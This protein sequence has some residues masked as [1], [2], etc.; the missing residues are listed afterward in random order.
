[1]FFI[2]LTGIILIATF[3]LLGFYI[4]SKACHSALYRSIAGNLSFSS[5]TIATNLKNMEK[6]SEVLLASP[7]IQDSLKNIDRDQKSAADSFYSDQINHQLIANYYAYRESGVAFVTIFN[8]RFANSTNI[9]AQKKKEPA[10]LN[11]ALK[12][13]KEAQ[14]AVAWTYGDSN[15]QDIYLTRLIREI[16]G[17]KFTS[18]G[19]ILISVDMDTLIQS[20]NLPFQSFENSSY[21]LYD[22]DN[23][24]YS[25]ANLSAELFQ[26]ALSV[27]ANE[28]K[29]IHMKNKSYFA[30]CT[31]IP[32]YG[33]HY[34]NL[35]PYNA[36]RSSLEFATLWMV[37]VLFL[38][39]ALAIGLS[40][41]LIRSI[42]V[43]FNTLLSKMDGLGEENLTLKETGYDYSERTDEIGQL[44]Q[45]FD[46]MAKQITH[47]INVNYKNQLLTKEAQIKALESQINPHFLYNALESINW[48]ARSEHHVEISQI[49]ESLGVLLREMLRN[50]ESLVTLAYEL[51][52]VQSYITIQKIR[53]EERL[54]FELKKDPDLD[55][56][57]LPPLTIQPL[58][59]NAIHYGME[60]SVEPCHIMIRI[61]K[62]ED[63]ALI[64]VM[65]EGSFFADDLM[66][67]LHR[68]AIIPHGFGI[69]LTNIE[70]RLKLIFGDKAGLNIENRE[71]YATAAMVIPFDA[72]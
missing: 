36:I 19:T 68:K 29:I 2:I 8:Q 10:V 25:S 40:R 53:F 59:E 23:P 9:F 34:I 43:H 66:S 30:A 20:V 28:Y 13:G 57:L 3:F 44:H 7:I 1:M 37:A 47:L 41:I 39:I 69:G 52:L 64:E 49:A 18:L 15:T 24:V 62:K 22:G 58:L 67:K 72:E 26:R 31:T 63:H 65:N 16:A 71:D 61:I 56:L 33:W 51:S 70:Q 60:E 42:M 45:R 12:K 50:K 6:M 17:M 21:I 54:I 46:W 32:E 4:Y 5:H 27:P 11:E 35:V 38:G 55:D 48:R 14:G